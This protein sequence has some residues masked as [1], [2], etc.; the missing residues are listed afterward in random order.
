MAHIGIFDTGFGGRYAARELAIL[1]PDD[2]FRVVDDAEHLPYGQRSEDEIISLTDRAIQPLLGCDVIVIA[3]NTA[4]TIAITKLREIHP[5]VRFVG[6]EPMIKTA[7]ELTQ[8]NTIAVLATPAT[9]RSPRYTALKQRWA[10]N[11][12]VIEPDCGTWAARIESGT[13]AEQTAIDLALQLTAEGADVISLACT[14][15]L[16]LQKAMQQAIGTKAQVLSPLRAVNAQIS[17]VLRAA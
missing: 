6:F 9:L 11:V 14:H 5:A 1:R 7:A 10:K 12:H 4:T 8:H 16:Y 3:C 17:R 15:Y 13:F 2:T